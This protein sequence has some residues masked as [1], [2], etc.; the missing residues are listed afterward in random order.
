MLANSGFARLNSDMSR[1]YVKAGALFFASVLALAAATRTPQL[2]ELDRIKA[3]ELAAA[4][5]FGEAIKLYESLLKDRPKDGGLHF[6]YG[7]ALYL[8]TLSTSKD[9]AAERKRRRQARAELKLAEASG[10]DQPL[11]QQ[12]LTTI[13]EDGSVVGHLY[14]RDLAANEAMVRGELAFNRRDLAA[15]RAEYSKALDRD[16][17]IAF[18][19][20]YIGDCFFLE[21]KHTEAQ[22]W[23]ERASQIDPAMEQAFRYWGDS[24]W[25]EGQLVPA[26]EKYAE[27]WI[28]WPYNGIAWRVLSERAVGIHRLRPNPTPAAPQATIKVSTKGVEIGVPSK[29][30]ALDLA[31]GV[32]RAAWIEKRNPKSEKAFVYR[33]SVAEEVEALNTALEVGEA[34]LHQAAGGQKAEIELTEEQTKSIQAL[35]AIRADGFLEPHILLTR[36][37]SDL[38]TEYATYRDRHR[39]V[40]RRY[41]RKYHVN[42]D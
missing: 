24:L 2:F 26:L 11:V 29:P 35:L 8:E 15:A 37:N 19:A 13:K 41:V 22:Q 39:D 27:A 18:A 12:L 3:D 34:A 31:Y 20:L 33:Q 1:A 10:L 38:A 42:L 7:Y 30:S 17:Q 28:A 4:G 25:E 14:S 21:K 32:S 36:A 23:F 40:L 9:G 6:R 16:G 5:K